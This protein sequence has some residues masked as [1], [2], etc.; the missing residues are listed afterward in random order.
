M[1]VAVLMS[2]VYDIDLVFHHDFS[3]V[4]GIPTASPVHRLRLHLFRVVAARSLLPRLNRGVL[5][6]RH[7]GQLATLVLDGL[8][9]VEARV[10]DQQVGTLLVGGLADGAV[11][12]SS[13]FGV[14]VAS[15]FLHGPVVR[16]LLSVCLSLKHVGVACAVEW[17]F[18]REFLH[19]NLFIRFG[20]GLQGDLTI[21]R[22]LVLQL[23]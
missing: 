21:L 11:F 15:E 18:L 13:Q 16:V 3:A 23:A 6:L 17:L 8:V 9:S 4:T 7:V 2:V 19:Q 10:L 22:Q 5:R 20:R 1:R 12:I 14:G